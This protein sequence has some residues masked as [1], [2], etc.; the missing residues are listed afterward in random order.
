MSHPINLEFKMEELRQQQT[1]TDIVM[2][3]NNGVVHAHKCVL[4]AACPYFE[5]MFSIDMVEKNTGCVQFKNISKEVIELIIKYLYTA[6]IPSL[7]DDAG[8]LRELIKTSHMLDLEDLYVNCW[9]QSSGNVNAE[10]FAGLWAVG[11]DFSLEKEGTIENFAQE[12]MK[13]IAENPNVQ[14]LTRDQLTKLIECVEHK[15]YCN[16]CIECIFIWKSIRN[17]NDRCLYNLLQSNCSNKKKETIED[18]LTREAVTRLPIV[19]EA[20]QIICK[21]LIQHCDSTCHYKLLYIHNWKLE[22]ELHQHRVIHAH[23]NKMLIQYFSTFKQQNVDLT[24]NECC[25]STPIIPLNIGFVVKIASFV[26]GYCFCNDTQILPSFITAPEGKRPSY[27]TSFITAP[28]GKLPSYDT[29]FITA[30][31]GK[32]PSLQLCSRFVTKF[33]YQLVQHP[34]T[35][36]KN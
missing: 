12:N 28:E 13:Q 34:A 19:S 29:S 6:Q 26:N 7:D 1:Y 17:E 4:V 20:Y 25:I 2:I 32:F 21:E 24:L 23:R 33:S 22:L 36:K 30:P 8:L 35:K 16:E 27:I 11:V 9:K 31:E 18:V 3:C 10:K 14:H 5:K 15:R